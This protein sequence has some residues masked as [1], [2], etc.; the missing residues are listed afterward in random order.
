MGRD[1]K[2]QLLSG[3]VTRTADQEAAETRYL[4]LFKQTCSEGKLI[5]QVWI[6]VV[7]SIK[8]FFFNPE[9]LVHG[10]F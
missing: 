7:T 10:F 5:F 3:T 6:L 1:R 4:L 8:D 9:V 2:Q